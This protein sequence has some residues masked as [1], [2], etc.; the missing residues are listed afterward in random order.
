MIKRVSWGAIFAGTVVIL[1]IQLFLSVIGISVGGASINPTSEAHPFSGIPVGAG[2]WFGVSGL[3]ALFVGGWVAGRLA[4][5]PR[6]VDGLLHGA[7]CW[8]LANLAFLFV[9]TTAVGTVLGGVTS[10]AGKALSLAGSGIGQLAK[11]G[12]QSANLDNIDITDIKNEAAV[13][14]KQTRKP[15]LQPKRL[16]RDAKNLG[17]TAEANAGNAAKNPQTA[18]TELNSLL[19]RVFAKGQEKLDAI[20][21]DAIANVLVARTG[22]PRSEALQTVDNWEATFNQAKAKA[23]QVAQQAEQK[24]RDAGEKVASGVSRAA[25]WYAVI[26]FLEALAACFGG[27]TGAPSE[28]VVPVVT[29]THRNSHAAA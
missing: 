26:L 1:G 22:M 7:V 13:L 10:V 17:N 6:R 18:D 9:M 28:A 3:I 21:R 20:D 27:F 16:E 24:A 23:K 14:L 4:G 5:V 19:D 25:A 8:G 12:L 11:E 15:E 29:R 2:I